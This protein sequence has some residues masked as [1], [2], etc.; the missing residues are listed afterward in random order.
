MLICSAR[1]TERETE[2]MLC[3]ASIFLLILLII[4]CFSGCSFYYDNCVNVFLLYLNTGCFINCCKM[5]W[6]CG[7]GPGEGGV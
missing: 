4:I 5:P 7:F 2:R 1:E 3:V 6:V